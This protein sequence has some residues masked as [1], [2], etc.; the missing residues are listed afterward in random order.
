MQPTTVRSFN[1]FI[2]TSVFNLHAIGRH[3]N[4]LMRVHGLLKENYVHE[5]DIFKDQ[6]SLVA[7]DLREKEEYDP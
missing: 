4:P 2:Y 5:S 7:G 3:V 1:R 6:E